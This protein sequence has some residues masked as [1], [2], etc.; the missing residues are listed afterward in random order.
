M[1]PQWAADDEDRVTSSMPTAFSGLVRLEQVN[2]HVTSAIAIWRASSD[3]NDSH[4][5]LFLNLDPFAPMQ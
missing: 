2:D 3:V 4:H 1:V 5:G